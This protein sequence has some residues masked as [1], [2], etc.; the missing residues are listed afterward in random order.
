ML[1]LL[2]GIQKYIKNTIQEFNQ[3]SESR[4]ESLKTFAEYISQKLSK[5]ESINL[6]FIC[7]HNSRRSQFA[8]VW[9]SV[10]AEFYGIKNIN[11]FSGGTEVTAFNIRAV[12]ALRNVGFNIEENDNSENP[13][14][15]VKYSDNLEHLK[16]YSKIYNDKFNPQ[17][18]FA[19]I[20]TCSDA[21]KN[22]PVVFGVEKRF[23]IRYEDPKKYDDSDL[24]ELMYE[25]TSREIAREMLY[26]FSLVKL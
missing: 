24:E 3:I 21:D 8:Q 11:C 10:S 18:N 25:E 13:I 26:A 20:M 7:T 1:L 14:Y 2:E 9:A 19:A 23:P 15:L 22:C 17:S 5:D 4:K 6:T 12:N 16:C